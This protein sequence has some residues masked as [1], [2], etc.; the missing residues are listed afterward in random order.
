MAYKD[1][2]EVVI[3]DADSFRAELDR[4]FDGDFTVT[5]MAPP[6]LNSNRCPGPPSQTRAWGLD[7]IGAV[8]YYS[9]FR[10]SPLN[11]FAYHAE[12]AHRELREWFQ[13]ISMTSSPTPRWF[14][15]KR[16]NRS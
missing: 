14:R 11:P 16:S 5:H 10:Q 13:N 6:L 12:A 2:F 9:I 7:D 8:L 1:E 3:D 4:E 15:P